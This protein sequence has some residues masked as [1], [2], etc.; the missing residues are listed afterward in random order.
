MR[1]QQFAC[2]GTGICQVPR[3]K[4]FVQRRVSSS[5]IRMVMDCV[6]DRGLHIAVVFDRAA[7]EGLDIFA[8]REAETFLGRGWWTRFAATTPA[9]F[10]QH[11][12]RRRR[13]STSRRYRWSIPESC[14]I[15]SSLATA[16][17][18]RAILDRRNAL[19]SRKLPVVRVELPEP[20]R[21]ASGLSGILHA[22]SRTP[23]F[24]SGLVVEAYFVDRFC[25]NPS[26]IFS[27]RF[28]IVPKRH[29]IF[30]PSCDSF[31]EHSR[32]FFH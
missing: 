9:L 27:R 23:T 30:F 25:R 4:P 12:R 32:F 18:Q 19:R 7:P 17:C 3:E 15:K 13:G 5:S 20:S 28:P 2:R 31:R 14:G 1:A 16:L 10:A 26:N 11:T 29:L 24:R 21:L 22:S 8:N 6:P